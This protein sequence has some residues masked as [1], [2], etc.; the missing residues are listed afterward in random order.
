[1]IPSGYVIY[2]DCFSRKILPEFWP[3][4]VPT[5][6]LSTIFQN[7]KMWIK[8]MITKSVSLKFFKIN[9]LFDFILSEKLLKDSKSFVIFKLSTKY[10]IMK[11]IKYL[12]SKATEIIFKSQAFLNFANY[13][14]IPYSKQLHLTLGFGYEPEQRK[15]LVDLAN[16]CINYR[17]PGEWEVRLYS[18]DSRAD[19]KMT[20]KVISTYKPKMDSELGLKINDYVYASMPSKDNLMKA[21]EATALNQQVTCHN[22]KI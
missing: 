20:F 7:I 6:F 4:K 18:R 12:A 2:L 10:L 11:Q 19:N 1:M 16:N 13:D 14:I 22:S 15:I 21:F 5:R 17:R 3:T 8:D 9:W